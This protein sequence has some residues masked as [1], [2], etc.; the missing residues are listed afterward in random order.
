M[1]SQLVVIIYYFT[2]KST[3]YYDIFGL[4][5]NLKE[6]GVCLPTISL[7]LL[8]VYIET[9]FRLKNIKTIDLCRPFAAHR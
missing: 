4:D 3:N 7:W 9:S 2:N 5:L 1:V 8:F 6:K